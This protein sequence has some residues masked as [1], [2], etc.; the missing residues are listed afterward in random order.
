M[1]TQNSMD[2]L[3]SLTVSAMGLSVVFVTLIVLSLALLIFSKIF[4]IGSGKKQTPVP[5]APLPV[6][7]EENE[8]VYAVLI[9]VISEE[10]RAPID[11]FRITEIKAI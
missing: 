6:T 3:Q 1:W 7:Q 8:D 10:L 5:A 9:A 4:A 11:S 2:F